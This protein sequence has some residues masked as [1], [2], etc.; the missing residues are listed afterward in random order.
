MPFY[1]IVV[2]YTFVNAKSTGSLKK[3]SLEKRPFENAM[4][5]D[6]RLCLPK[7]FGEEISDNFLSDCKLVTVAV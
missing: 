6:H 3:A 4:V 2:K 5:I 7:Y 1:Y